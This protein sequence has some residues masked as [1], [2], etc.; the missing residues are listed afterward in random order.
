MTTRALI[1]GGAGFIGS[2]LAERLTNQ[3][4]YS[5]AWSWS[6]MTLAA[7]TADGSILVGTLTGKVITYKNVEAT[8]EEAT[9]VAVKDTIRTRVNSA[10]PQMTRHRPKPLCSVKREPRQDSQDGL[11]GARSSRISVERHSKS[12]DRARHLF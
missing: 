3:S 4:V 5:L 10:M 6:G 8:M 7:A 2:H 9:L 1:T 12:L 11:A